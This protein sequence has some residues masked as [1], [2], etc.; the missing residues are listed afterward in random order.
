[1]QEISFLLKVIGHALQL[2]DLLGLLI[3][4]FF[5]SYLVIPNTLNGLLKIINLLVLDC[6]V[7]VL[8]VLVAVRL[9]LVVVLLVLVV[10]LFVLVAV[11]G[12]GFAH[13]CTLLLLSQSGSSGADVQLH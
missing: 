9:V 7:A 6:I 12:H 5:H 1:M 2:L 13:M 3:L 4:F 8:F 10:V 11:R